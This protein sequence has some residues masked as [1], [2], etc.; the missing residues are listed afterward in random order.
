MLDVYE[1]RKFIDCNDDL[2]LGS[3]RSS[4]TF[5]ATDHRTYF[6]KV[7]AFDGDAGGETFVN[8]D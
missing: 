4:V 1:Q 8:V 3:V 5:S 7:A 2:A 6:F